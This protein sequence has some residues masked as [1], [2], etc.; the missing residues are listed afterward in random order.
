MSLKLY[1]PR[2]DKSPNWSIRGVYLGERV[3]RTTGVTDKKTAAKVLASIK[4]QI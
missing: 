1:P 3:N 4:E 2:K